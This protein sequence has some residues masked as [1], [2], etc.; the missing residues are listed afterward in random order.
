MLIP[1]IKKMI[2]VFFSVLFF[3]PSLVTG[4]QLAGDMK[5]A[6]EDPLLVFAAISDVHLTDDNARANMLAMG[7]YD[8]QSSVR[9][10]DALVFCGDNT[11]HGYEAQYEL[12]R[13]TLADYN[14]AK[15]IVLAE[16]NHDTWTADDYGPA[17]ALFLKYNREISGRD[18]TEAY[19]SVEINGY[20]IVCM[21]SEYD[22]TDAY[23][24]DAQLAWLQRELAD[25]T[26]DGKPVFVISHWP[27]NYT[28][29]LP[30]T[31]EGKPN[32]KE[33]KG[34]LG[35]QSD[36]V[37]EILS[38]FENVYYITGHLHAGLS[39]ETRQKLDPLFHYTSIETEG[40]LHRVNLPSYMYPAVLG[41]PLNGQGFVFE[42]YK[43]KVMVRARSY[44][45]GVWLEAY[46]QTFAIE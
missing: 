17:K 34:G 1:F 31:W 33:N 43:D 40:S 35:D 19:Y 36:A 41:R 27:I 23:I 13:K 28:H 3:I 44:S 32:E 7:L 9:P 11:D 6:E 39:N 10:L 22:H 30:G 46:S 14:A 29:G 24:S 42:V 37:A 2:S 12:L 26:A 15:Q 25:A 21:A 4:K 38:R 45:A 8:M 16:G 18:L 5:T 20:K